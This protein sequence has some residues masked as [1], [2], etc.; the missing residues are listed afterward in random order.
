MYEAIGMWCRDHTSINFEN[1]YEAVKWFLIG[2][3]IVNNRI[4]PYLGDYETAL[5]LDPVIDPPVGDINDCVCFDDQGNPINEC[6]E[7]PR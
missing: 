2:G 4:E 3:P 1:D 6:N 5:E 7:C